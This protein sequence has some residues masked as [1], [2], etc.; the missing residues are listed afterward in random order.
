MKL[1]KNIGQA[2]LIARIIIALVALYL[3]FQYHWGFYILAIILGITIYTGYCGLYALLGIK[4]CKKCK[5]K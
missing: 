1:K 2:D 4:T 3:G 5:L